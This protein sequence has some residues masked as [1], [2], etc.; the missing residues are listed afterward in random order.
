M[1]HL[2]SRSNPSPVSL[3]GVDKNNLKV[4]D[5]QDSIAKKQ[6]I[7]LIPEDTLHSSLLS[8]VAETAAV[9]LGLPTDHSGYFRY[10]NSQKKETCSRR[11]FPL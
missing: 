4:S 5:E 2:K 10:I 1:Y 3:P 7:T 8:G 11:L 6:R 9:K